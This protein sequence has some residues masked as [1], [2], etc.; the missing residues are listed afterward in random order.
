MFE[1]LGAAWGS[2]LEIHAELIHHALMSN[3]CTSL[4]HRSKQQAADMKEV[5]SIM[6]ES[7]WQDDKDINDCQG[8]KKPFSVGRRKVWHHHYI[9]PPQFRDRLVIHCRNVLSHLLISFISSFSI[10]VE[11]VVVSS[12][13][14]ART[15]QCSLP[16]ALSQF[17]SVTPAM[18]CC[19]KEPPLSWHLSPL[20]DAVTT[21]LFLFAKVIRSMWQIIIDC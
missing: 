10:T 3:L 9:N 16:P 15:I 6:K 1:K 11:V 7:V 14:L 8:C 13:M 19:S 12:A 20:I 2:R 17:V 21:V 5:S 18:L 4:S